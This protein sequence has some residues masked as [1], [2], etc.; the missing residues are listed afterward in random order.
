MYV[1]ALHIEGHRRFSSFDLDLN[2][3]FNII[4]G[5]NETGK[6]RAYP[7]TSRSNM[8]EHAK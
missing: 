1:K 3:T 6:S 4:V 8:N 5:D 7:R 2:P